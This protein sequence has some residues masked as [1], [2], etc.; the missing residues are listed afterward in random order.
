[1]V[2][3]KWFCIRCDNCGEVINY[4]QTSSPMRALEKEKE[5]EPTEVIVTLSKQFCNK[6]CQKE[7]L[8]KRR[9]ARE[10]QKAMDKMME[11]FLGDEE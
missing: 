11:K 3:E 6:K 2:I 7:W 1:M 9:Q 4:W 5:G 10:K 8:A